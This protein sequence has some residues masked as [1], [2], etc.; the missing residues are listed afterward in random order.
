MGRAGSYGGG[1]V[2]EVMLYESRTL[3]RGAEYHPLARVPI[4]A[5]L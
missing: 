1:R 2:T 3:G 5:G 4:G